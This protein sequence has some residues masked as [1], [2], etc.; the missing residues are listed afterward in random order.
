MCIYGVLSYVVVGTS[1][2]EEQSLLFLLFGLIF[3]TKERDFWEFEFELKLGF[4]WFLQ[5]FSQNME[6]NFLSLCSKESFPP[7]EEKNNNE[8]SK[9]SGIVS[10]HSTILH[11]EVW[12]FVNSVFFELLNFEFL[13][14]LSFIIL[15][16]FVEKLNSCTKLLNFAWLWVMTSCGSCV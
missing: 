11:Y 7:S 14:F 4:H 9:E 16:W 3:I 10:I 5:I 1:Q 6:R 15:V 12:F 2:C 13:I 8:G